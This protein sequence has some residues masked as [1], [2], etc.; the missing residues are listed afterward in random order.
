MSQAR[1][2]AGG[3]PAG[4]PFKPEYER[5]PR[6]VAKTM[7][8]DPHGV[9]LLDVRTQEEWDLVHVPGSIHIPLNEL[10]KRADEIELEDGQELAVICHHGV[11]SLKAALALRAL[12][13]P[14]AK[15]V[16]GGIDLWSMAGEPAPDG[17]AVPRYAREGGRCWLI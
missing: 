11:R 1:L 16:A 17:T 5:A 9:T 4:Y 10:E 13:F 14:S 12:G 7:R 2:D 6:E 8:D 3:L 15:S